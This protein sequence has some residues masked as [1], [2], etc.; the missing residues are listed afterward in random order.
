MEKDSLDAIDR[1]ILVAVQ[2]RPDASIAELAEIVGL[3]QTPCW[4]RLRRLRDDGVLRER[5]WLLDPAKLGLTINVFAELRLKQ[6]DEETLEQLERLARARPE[7]IECYSMSGESDYLLRIVVKSMQDY[8]I[9]LK[10]VLLHFPGVASINSSFALK[11]IKA[12]T[13]LPI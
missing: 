2:D 7:I 3:S 9:L 8:E 4:R 13:K 10:K 1:K 12:T 11:A 5:A 6:H